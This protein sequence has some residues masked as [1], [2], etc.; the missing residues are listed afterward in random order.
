MARAS[1]T[2][3]ACKSAL[4]K[5]QNMGFAWS[6]NPYKGCV[7]ACAYC[8]ARSNHL[9]LGLNAVEDF[10]TKLFVKENFVEV[11]RRELARPS[12]QREE[13]AIGTATDP[14][15]PIEGKFR[16]TR[17]ALAALA[18]FGTPGH[19]VT[20]SP[21]VIRDIDLLQRLEEQAGVR[22]CMT[23]TTLDEDV[24]R[25]MEPGTAPPKQRIRAIRM[26]ADAGIPCGVFL[27]PVL[28]KLTD[29]A[30]SIRAVL[31][32]VKDAGGR[33]V[34]S[35]P[36][37]LAADVRDHYLETVEANYPELI[38]RY[39]VNYRTADA[40]MTYRD[41]LRERIHRIR[42]EVGLSGEGTRPKPRHHPPE[43]LA[44]TI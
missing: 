8:Y 10:E 12:W 23:I 26:L 30:E 6:L 33:F 11:L 3:I 7:H 15:Q 27:A 16:L 21:L 37:R 2:T 9:Y 40:P 28:P 19:I 18:D 5:V 25:V 29:S 17:G 22:V 39:R 4:N 13:V 42:A 14:Y 43:Q 1:Y 41:A 38:E 44:L 32:A 34:W 31:Q 24:W 20:K 35:G 36:L